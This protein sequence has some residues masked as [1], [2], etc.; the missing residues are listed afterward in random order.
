MMDP[1]F[2]K[3]PMI[4]KY[5]GVSERTLRKWLKLGLPY[6]KLPTGCILIKTA[7]VDD[8]IKSF[9]VNRNYVDEIADD[10]LRNFP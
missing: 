6:S 10:I 4:A 1:A 7:D 8:F 5:A 2:G 9:R 3:I